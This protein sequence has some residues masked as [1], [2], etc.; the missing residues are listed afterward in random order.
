MANVGT[1]VNNGTLYIG[2]GATLNLTTQFSVNDVPVGADYTI[3]GTFHAGPNDAFANLTSIEGTVVLANGQTTDITPNGGVMTIASGGQLSD[4]NNSTITI[5]GDVTNSGYL[6][7]GANYGN[8]TGGT[9]NI[10]GNLTNNSGTGFYMYDPNDVT[11]VGGSLTNNGYIYM[12]NSNQTLAVAGDMT[13]AA[14]GLV[15]MYYTGTTLQVGGTLTNNGTINVN[16]GAAVDPP[17]LNNLGT[18][19]IDSMSKL[20]VGTGAAGLGYTQLANGTLGEIIAS[21][22]S[23]G[24]INVAGMASLDGTLKILLQA[25]YDPTIGTT[26]KFLN[27]STGQIA[28]TFANVQNLYFNGGTEMWAVSYDP[29][30]FFVALTAEAAVGGIDYWVGGKVSGATAASGAWAFRRPLMMWRFTPAPKTM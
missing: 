19:N 18:I 30:G 16:Y 10:T 5:H 4:G 8:S 13:N 15:N 26:F 27:S 29:G 14:G 25:G 23:Y 2:T 6:N 3:L 1:L 24:I 11:N 20:V 12:G 17:V 22:S 7:T 9:L 28:G 21:G